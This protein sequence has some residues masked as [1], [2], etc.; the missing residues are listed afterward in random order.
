MNRSKIS[1]CLGLKR[2]TNQRGQAIAE[3]AIGLSLVVLF[4][5]GILEFGRGYMIANAVI[6]AARVGA[7]AAAMEPANNR[8]TSGIIINSANIEASV[9]EEIANTVGQAVANAVT[10]QVSQPTLLL[11]R[12]RVTVTGNIPYM[13]NL[14]GTSFNL[15]R[16]VTYRDQ[17]R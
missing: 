15:S 9:R 1:G 5:L 4:M 14:V 8:D 7:R 3:T 6:N 2:G 11:P 16:T 10:V 17:A 13:F 12:A